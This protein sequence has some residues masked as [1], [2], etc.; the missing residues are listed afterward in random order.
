MYGKQTR[1]AIGAMSRLA[2]V[3][4]GGTTLLSAADIAASRGVPRPRVAK[5]LAVLS[6]AGLVV[7]APGPGGGF[8][9]ADDPANITLRDVFV[10]FERNEDALPCPFGD[11]VCGTNGPCPLHDDLT[12]VREALARLLDRTTFARFQTA[13]QERHADVLSE[14][15]AKDSADNRNTGQHAHE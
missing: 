6:Q 13:H 3:Y 10:L 15:P 2:E 12:S 11:G 1:C 9:L 4:D 14:S 7:G 5:V 8:T